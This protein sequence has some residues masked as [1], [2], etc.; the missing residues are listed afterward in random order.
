MPTLQFYRCRLSGGEKEKTSTEKLLTK[1]GSIYWN[2]LVEQRE[3][4]CVRAGIAK[5]KIT[6]F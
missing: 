5:F 2:L 1:P 3:P 6:L 4:L